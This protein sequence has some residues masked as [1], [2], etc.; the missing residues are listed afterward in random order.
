M[1]V[2]Q[3]PE[4]EITAACEFEDIMDS[5]ASCTTLDADSLFL[6]SDTISTLINEGKTDQVS[7]YY[8]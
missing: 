4:I 7:R 1:K 8:Q 6:Y 2:Y 5:S 3:A